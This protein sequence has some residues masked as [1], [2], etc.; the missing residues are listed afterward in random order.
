MFYYNKAMYKEA[1]ASMRKIAW[2]NGLS[3][4]EIEKRFNF[5]F[6]KEVSDDD[7]ENTSLI[8]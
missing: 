4:E 6:D 8:L 7:N 5:N 1:R 3:K 2:Y